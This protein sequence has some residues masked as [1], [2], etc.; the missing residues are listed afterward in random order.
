MA[1]PCLIPRILPAHNMRV[2][3]NK[4]WKLSNFVF[5]LD[6]NERTPANVLALPRNPRET[7][8]S[9]FKSRRASLSCLEKGLWSYNNFNLHIAGENDTQ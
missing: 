7:R 4:Y 3:K 9:E 1:E 5:Y 2:S 6:H 8:S